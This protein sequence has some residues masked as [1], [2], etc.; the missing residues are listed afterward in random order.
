MRRLSLAGPKGSVRLEFTGDWLLHELEGEAVIDCSVTLSFLEG[1]WSCAVDERLTDGD[2]RELAKALARCVGHDRAKLADRFAW[3]PFDADIYVLFS[4]YGTTINLALNKHP[5]TESLMPLLDQFKEETGMNAQFLILPEAEYFRKIELDM[6]TGA[7]EYDVF[8]T[9]PTRNWTYAKPGWLE[10]LEGYLADPK[11]THPEY[12][13]ADFF[14]LLRE[15]NTWDKTVGGGVGKGSTWA[16]PVHVETYVLAYRKDI[17]D[18]KGIKVPTNLDEWADAAKKATFKDKDGSQIYGTIQRGVRDGNTG[19][20][21]VSAYRAYGNVDFDDNFNVQVNQPG[22]V[23]FYEQWAQTIKETST[24]GWT[25]VTWY[26][27]KESFTQ[28]KYAMYFDCDFFGAGY[29]DK[30]TSKV[31]G[32]VGYA[33]PL[34]PSPDKRWTNVFTWA[35]GMSAASKNK[36]AAWYLIQWATS[37]QRLLDATTKYNNFNPTRK[38]IFD[39]P[40]VQE[41]M[42]SWGS[43]T[44]LPT[45]LDNLTKYAKIAYRPNPELPAFTVRTSQALQEIW[46]GQPAQKVMD[47]AAEDINANMTKAGWRKA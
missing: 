41:T 44:Y 33:P 26:E 4:V 5:Y 14:P 43:G 34:A 36:D 18:E 19:T 6:S 32:K 46:N 8:M 45:V 40:K 16:I 35:L 3:E 21:F 39:D 27:G 9:G 30:N 23:K 24:P 38:S 47:A 11:K 28:G 10:P 20:G 2:V 12:D 31:A 25:N 17:F 1:G 13:H 22:A 37:K 42:K 29:E 7:G 15:A